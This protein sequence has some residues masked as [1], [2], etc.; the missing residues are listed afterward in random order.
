VGV[1]VESSERSYEIFKREPDNTTVRLEAVKGIEE[2]QKRLAE[3]K[4]EGID[5]Y[6]IFDPLQARVIDPAD[7]TTEKDPLAP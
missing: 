3:L 2:A 4:R 7:P 5:Q 6:F 1:R